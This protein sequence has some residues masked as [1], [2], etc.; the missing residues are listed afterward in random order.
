[1]WCPSSACCL[2]TGPLWM[3]FCV[4]SDCLVSCLMPTEAATTAGLSDIRAL[5]LAFL[6][7]SSYSFWLRAVIFLELFFTIQLLQQLNRKQYSVTVRKHANFCQ[8]VDWSHSYASLKT[9]PSWLMCS[10]VGM[11]CTPVA[12]PC[13]F[14]HSCLSHVEH[15]RCVCEDVLMITEN[16]AAALLCKGSL[17][18]NNAVPLL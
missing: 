9:T 13:F 17:P 1:M 6:T 11:Y 3:M 10:S 18:L 8:Y 12:L 15:V 2:Q 16:V 7:P 5:K 14:L 4:V